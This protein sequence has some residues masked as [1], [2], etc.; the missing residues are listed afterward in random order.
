MRIACAFDH[1]G[2]PLRE[3]LMALLAGDGHEVID[4]GT[5]SPEP[6]DYPDKALDVAR[7][8]LSGSAERGLLACGS[9][10][11]VAIAASKVPG[12]RA[13][14]AHDTYTA[15]QGVEHDDVNVLCL[16]AR[17]IGPALAEDIVRAFL[18]GSFSGEDR[19]RRR[20]AKVE[21][22]ERG[23]GLR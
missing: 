12:I 5:D 16:G 6:V 8:V 19:H 11:G 1:A 22:I 21:A 2:L 10:A 4:L 7:A 3:P 14:C 20:L 17:V 9:G 15:H 23:E 18:G 13:A